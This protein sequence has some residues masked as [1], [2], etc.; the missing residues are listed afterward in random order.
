MT[1]CDIV[2]NAGFELAFY[3]KPPSMKLFVDRHERYQKRT[4]SV[5]IGVDVAR[6]G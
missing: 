6:H 5:G 4:A 1:V 3:A 2:E